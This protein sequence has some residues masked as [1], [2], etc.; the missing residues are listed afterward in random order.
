LR[1]LPTIPYALVGYGGFDLARHVPTWMELGDFWRSGQFFPCWAENANYTLGDTRFCFYPP[2]SF[3]V[4][5]ALS[6]VLPFRF[7]PAAYVW[8]AFV[9]GGLSMYFASKPFLAETDRLKAAALY[10][11]SPYLILSSL[12][13]FAAAELLTQAWLPLIFMFFYQVLWL[14]GWRSTLLLGC[15]LGLTWITNV[16]ASIVL[17][18]GWITVA[19]IV[20]AHQKS[21][22]PIALFIVSEII[23]GALAAFYLMPVWAEQGWIEK[24]AALFD[25]KLFLVFMP[26]STLKDLGPF[27]LGCWALAFGAA[28]LTGVYALSRGKSLREDSATLTWVEISL[29][30]FVFQLP[31]SAFL[32]QHL[33]QLRF[34]DFPFRF[35]AQSGV[36]LPL[37]LFARGAK[38]ILRKPSYVVV[39]V[40]ALLP[41]ALYLAPIGFRHQLRTQ[42]APFLFPNTSRVYASSSVEMRTPTISDP[43]AK[44]T[45]IGY[46]GWSS[47]VPAGATTPIA[48]TNFPLASSEEPTPSGACSASL[49]S[50]RKGQKILET[51]S[52]AP[53]KVRVKIYYYPYW[54]AVDE[55]GDLLPTAK[56]S[57]GLL[58][59]SVPSGKHTVRLIFRAHSGVR[60]A[61]LFVSL[62]SLVLIAF[63]IFKSRPKI[64]QNKVNRR[65]TEGAPKATA[66]PL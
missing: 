51:D 62:V 48:P 16:P 22:R 42:F 21:I 43:V 4:G 49:E 6:L 44:W 34:A 38:T 58:L 36:A 46:P 31:I 10:M 13:N 9:I 54:R 50:P 61:G 53:C 14:K 24:N 59:V 5:A 45:R 11:M 30:S 33:P 60:T 29:V 63:A 27:R 26:F 2:V 28:V 12:V 35:M 25:F 57:Y 37:I 47:F 66:E 52:S 15:M 3:A 64:T 41:F 56:D 17:L 55:S 32:W 40:L 23:A 1:C 19:A 8:L 20:A 7:V 18:Y 39:G 65:G